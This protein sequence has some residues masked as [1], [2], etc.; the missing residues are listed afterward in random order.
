MNKLYSITLKLCVFSITIKGFAQNLPILPGPKMPESIAISTP[1]VMSFQKYG[2]VPTNLYNGK[3]D[4][5]I[6]FHEIQLGK[7]KIPINLTYNSGGVKVDDIASQVGLGWNLNAGGNILKSINDLQDGTLTYQFYPPATVAIPINVGYNRKYFLKN[8]VYNEN[9]KWFANVDS[10]P[11]FYF[12]NA[13]GLNNVFTVDDANPND[14]QSSHT[15]RSYVASFLYPKGHRLLT[16]TVENL[17]SFQGIGFTGLEDGNPNLNIPTKPADVNFTA[18]FTFK[19]YEITNEEGLVYKF[20]PGNFIETRSLPVLVDPTSARLDPSYSL[21]LNTY[22]L[23]SI[24]DPSTQQK[25]DFIYESYQITQPQR[26]K[27]LSK[28]NNVGNSDSCNYGFIPEFNGQSIYSNEKLIKY[29]T[30]TRL[31]KII[32]KSGEIEFVYLNNRQDYDDKSLDFIRIKDFQGNIIKSYHLLYSYFDSKEGCS[33]KECK[34]LRL[35]QIDE[36]YPLKTKVYYK[37]DYYY[38]DKLPKRFSYEQDFLGYY[39]NNGFQST[40]AVG[41]NIPGPQ[42]KLYFY[43]NKGE[44]SILP[45][46]KSNDSNGRQI[47]GDYSFAPNT[48]SLTGLLKRVTYETGGYS[49]FQYENHKFN[50]AGA[51]YFAGGARI[52]SQLINDDKGNS[53]EIEYEY[54]ESD[55]KTSGYISSLPVFAYPNARITNPTALPSQWTPFSFTTFDFDKSGLELTRDNFVGYSRVIER[56]SG[57]GSTESLFYSSKDY[58]DVKSQKLP[59]DQCGQ[60]LV[61]NSNFP[62]KLFEDLKG[63]RGALK[64]KIVYNESGIKVF[65]TQNLYDY[66]VF[67]SINL[68]YYEPYRLT[69]NQFY[70]RIRFYNNFVGETSKINKER[71]ILTKATTTEYLTTG[72]KITENHFTYNSS[73]NFPFLKEERILDGVSELKFK[74]FY[75]FDFPL[76]LPFIGSFINQNRLTE[77]FIHQ[78]WKDNELIS[79]NQTNFMDFGSGIILEKSLSTAKGGFPYEETTVIDSRDNNGNITQFH[80][81]SGLNTVLIWGYNKT[82]I[83]AKI[84]NSTY[85]QIQSYESNLQLLSNTGT[86]ANLISSLNSLRNSLPNAMIT[87]YTH[88]PLIGVSTITDP[89]GDKITYIYD[90]FNRL[91]EIK[92]KDGNILSKNEYNF[93]Q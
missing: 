8:P 20:S 84:E 77:P 5:I 58:P 66:E 89:K 43:P 38:L 62:G 87:T 28:N 92:D 51:E 57:N 65:E 27:L 70:P 4:M 35:Y 50:F 10:S 15:N 60:Y 14:W 63:R 39:N 81:Q 40:T 13:P 49:E 7:I 47:T 3:V 82:L 36:D 74:N 59:R 25:V 56:E 37:F 91:K 19:N 6:P 71:N 11:D 30:A 75:C 83:I 78:V 80:D 17:G 68:E 69:D 9:M 72:N 42:P 29:H 32:C 85:S 88:R 53:R 46:Q 31:K 73:P 55:G 24:Y 86:E 12:V 52:K 93:K 21:S 33:Q 64:Q 48:Y 23:S 45:F 67:S 90:S 44:F 26:I 22:N 34:R 79:S 76:Y 61:D 1:D 54:I 18:F 41:T 2:N 16:P